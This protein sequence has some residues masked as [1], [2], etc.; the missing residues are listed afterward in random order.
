MPLLVAAAIIESKGYILITR[1][2]PDAPYPHLW[3]FPGGKV[4][5]GE[6]PKDCVIREIREEL[7]IE[8]AVSSIYDVVYY[9][10][11]ERDVLVL[12]WLCNWT[13]GRVQNLEVAEHRWV[14]PA[15]IRFFDLLPADIALAQRL[16]AEFGNENTSRL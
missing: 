5:E 4:E 6:N 3:E 1:R 8:I 11:P 12:A 14:K 7:D 16:A 15:E 13:S 10:Y 2:K 9:R